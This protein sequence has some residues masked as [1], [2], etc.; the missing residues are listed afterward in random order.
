MRRRRREPSNGREREERRGAG[1]TKR[2]SSAVKQAVREGGGERRT[3][4]TSHSAAYPKYQ[5]VE[6]DTILLISE[7]T[8]HQPH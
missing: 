1:Y 7:L 3:G 6:R 8:V 2:L 5:I 4:Q